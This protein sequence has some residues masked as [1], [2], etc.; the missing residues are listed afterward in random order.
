MNFDN[1]LVRKPWGSEYELYKNPML[2]IWHLVINPGQQ[3]SLHCHPNKKTGLLVL[4][5]LAELSFLSGKDVL[6]KLD[7]RIIRPTVFHSTKNVGTG[8][9]HLLEVETPN[10]KHDLV[11]LEDKYARAGQPYEDESNFS[12]V[13]SKIFDMSDTS[14]EFMSKYKDIY[15]VRQV[16]DR[17]RVE[18]LDSCKLIIL[19][20]YVYRDDINVAGPGD[21]LD[22]K[23]LKLLVEKF[24]MTPI[25][26][27]KLTNVKPS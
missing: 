9:L 18:K 22:D 8:P 27:A 21:I 25:H 3:T 26:V 7:K 24:E 1:I 20:G 17:D 6:H 11:R 23:V 15:S 2:S 16:L 19:D 14:V 12:K 4:D 13:E 10:N 5:G